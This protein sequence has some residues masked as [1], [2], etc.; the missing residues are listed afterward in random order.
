[1]GQQCDFWMFVASVI[2]STH[3]SL[4]PLP[5]YLDSRCFIPRLH[6]PPDKQP[7]TREYWWHIFVKNLNALSAIKIIACLIRNTFKLTASVHA[8]ECDIRWNDH[9]IL[10]GNMDYAW[11]FI[12]LRANKVERAQF[13]VKAIILYSSRSMWSMSWPLFQSVPHWRCWYSVVWQIICSFRGVWDE[14]IRDVQRRTVHWKRSF[15]MTTQIL[16]NSENQLSVPPLGLLH[17][18]CSDVWILN[19]ITTIWSENQRAGQRKL[20]ES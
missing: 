20:V 14:S 12:Q 8:H 4:L 5:L 6:Q 18:V 16:Q 3:I 13:L 1:M 10:C 17:F 2:D 7:P 9:D 19:S 11:R 15:T